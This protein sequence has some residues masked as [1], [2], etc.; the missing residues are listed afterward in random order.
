VFAFAFFL[1][2][3]ISVDYRVPLADALGQIR[4]ILDRFWYHFG[5]NFPALSAARAE[6]LQG[7]RKKLRKKLAENFQRT[8]KKLTRNAKNLQRTS[9]KLMQRTF[10]Q[11]KSQAAVSVQTFSA[12]PS[13]AR[14]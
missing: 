6:L 9:N 8:I 3:Q 2:F 5:S 14:K 1:F 4:S 7:L 13:H 12:V 11:T 10:P